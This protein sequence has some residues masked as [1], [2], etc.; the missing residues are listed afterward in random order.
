MKALHGKKGFTLIECVIAIAVFAALTGM[1][2]MIMSQTIK[3]SK[4]ATDAETDLNNVVQNVVQ[5]STNKTYGADSKHLTMTFKSTDDFKMTYSTVDG[6]KNFIECTNAACKNHANN[7]DYMSYIYDTTVYQNASDVEKESYKISYWFGTDSTTNFLKCPICDQTIYLNNITLSCLS[8]GE[9]G[10]AD[11]T[12]TVSGA[13]TNRFAF[14]KFSGSYTCA[15]CGGGNVV[16]M[17]QDNAG[18]TVPITDSPTADA[19]FMVSGIVSNAIRYGAVPLNDKD[20][21]KNLVSSYCSNGTTDIKGTTSWTYTPNKNASIPGYYTL[22]LS[23]TDTIPAGETVTVSLK[24]PGGYLAGID[25]NGTTADGQGDHPYAAFIRTENISETDK[26]SNLIISGITDLKKNNI[27]VK[28]SL[29][30]YANNNSFDSDYAN[31]DTA[32]GVG[33]GGYWFAAPGSDPKSFSFSFP[34][35]D[36]SIRAARK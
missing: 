28:F 14:N 33:L 11:S 32:K 35:E 6:Y 20:G 19:D 34:R 31:E 10:T 17:V 7:L 16:Q 2:L 21:I 12:I 18:N 4:K 25:K 22:T 29:T 24:L 13:T 8:C 36:S 1:V 9:T 26:A 23:I 5:D 27:K 15:N 30:N 3:L